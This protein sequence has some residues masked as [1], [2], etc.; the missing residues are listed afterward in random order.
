MAALN[1]PSTPTTNQTY[2]AN[3]KTWTWDGVSWNSTNTAAITSAD[4]TSA[5]GYTPVPEK[6]VVTLADSNI[7]TLDASTTDLA[8][9]TNTQAAGTLTIN[10]PAGTPVE[11]Q[12]ILL[13]ITCTNPQTLSFNAIFVGSSDAPLPT[14]TSGASKED[15]LGFAYNSVDGKWLLIAKNFGF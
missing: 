9:Q 7:I 3:G 4:I 14:A 11:G 1:F 8:L 13:R 12:Q 10:A 15:Y 2:S 5:L 6:R